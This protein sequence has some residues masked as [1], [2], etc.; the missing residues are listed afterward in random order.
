MNTT[1]LCEEYLVP[2]GFESKIKYISIYTLILTENEMLQV[3]KF[4]LFVLEPKPN[5]FHRLF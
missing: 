2:G 3:A 4:E 5:P 1:L